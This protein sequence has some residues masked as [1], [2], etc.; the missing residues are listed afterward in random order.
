VVV[1]VLALP[2][3]AL[4][5]SGELT[6]DLGKESEMTKRKW[7]EMVWFQ[8]SLSNFQRVRNQLNEATSTE[9]DQE[10]HDERDD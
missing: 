10:G 1:D 6:K 3:L 4:Q 2:K 9:H 7:K 5:F 8:P